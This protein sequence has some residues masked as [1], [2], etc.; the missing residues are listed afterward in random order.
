MSLQVARLESRTHLAEAR[1]RFAVAE[2]ARDSAIATV[3][4][5]AAH[6]PEGSGSKRIQEILA[7]RCDLAG[8]HGLVPG[9]SVGQ[10]RPAWLPMASATIAW[11]SG[12]NAAASRRAASNTSRSAVSA[13]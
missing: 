12:L 4:I 1:A 13:P 3:G 2:A 8:G 5:G 7:A 11:Q 6:S 10:A 9:D